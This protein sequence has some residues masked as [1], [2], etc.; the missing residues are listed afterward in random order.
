M[1]LLKLTKR[2]YFYL[3]ILTTLIFQ[4][5]LSHKVSFFSYY[6]ELLALTLLAF[7]VCSRAY[8]H[9]WVT[10]RLGFISEISII[11]YFCSTLLSS[12]MYQYQNIKISF[13][14]AFLGI[15][16]FLVFWGTKF[17][18]KKYGFLT[19]TKNGR[20]ILYIS[21][22]LFGIIVNFYYVKNIPNWFDPLKYSNLLAPV[23]LCGVSVMLICVLLM[24]W[25]GTKIEWCCLLLQ[26]ENLLFST[27]AK[28]YAAV[29]LALFFL[30]IVYGKV[31][32]VKLIH[33][34]IVGAGLVAVAWDKIYLYY[35][36]AADPTRDY[37]RYRLTVTGF[38]ILKD[39]FPL[40]TGW[41]TWGSYYAYLEYSP[42]YFIYGLQSHHE[43][44]IQN[45]KYMMD[46]YLGSVLGESGFIG[47]VTLAIFIIT[48]LVMIIKVRDRKVY[49][50]GMFSISYLFITFIEETGFANPALIGLAVA[51]GMVIA[52]CELEKDTARMDLKNG[53]NA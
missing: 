23:Y 14:A 21:I 8:S 37:A 41:G 9:L 18:Y 50:A 11:A 26:L 27:K 28:G 48:L 42:V 36:F 47:V 12:F 33:I 30:L 39:Y 1:N 44:G 25:R 32:R 53:E 52:K 13:A 15:K 16:W 49:A 24:D 38:Q 22:L 19:G 6:D 3:F 5:F 29:V 51:L 45:K 4:D 2:E 7:W 20:N 34:L 17:L 35:I 46:T 10:T 43:L 31:K 40:G